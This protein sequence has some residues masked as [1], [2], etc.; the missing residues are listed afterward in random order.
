MCAGLF[1]APLRSG[2]FAAEIGAAK[3][4]CGT[5]LKK[6]PATST[7]PHASKIFRS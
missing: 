4:S 3:G 6:C 1:G 2:S 7:I 5:F